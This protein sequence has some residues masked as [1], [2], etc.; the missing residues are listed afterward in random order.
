MELKHKVAD[1]IINNYHV[2]IAAILFLDMTHNS[3]I[4][5]IEIIRC[6]FD[7]DRY[8]VVFWKAI[9]EKVDSFALIITWALYLRESR[10]H[11][12]GTGTGIKD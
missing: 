7:F 9:V 4:F 8:T 6:T 10:T 2:S 12:W 3:H 11:V 5:R 1:E